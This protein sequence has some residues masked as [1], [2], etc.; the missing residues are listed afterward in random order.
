MV[1]PLGTAAW[2]TPAI[3]NTTSKKPILTQLIIAAILSF[4]SSARNCAF[5]YTCK[6]M[7]A[8]LFVQN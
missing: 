4:Q 1:G 8:N 6:F 2:L 7:G 5:N 3:F